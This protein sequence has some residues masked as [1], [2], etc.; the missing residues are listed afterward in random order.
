MAASDDVDGWFNLVKEAIIL[1]ALG[2]C[3]SCRVKS[4]RNDYLGI[5]PPER[6]LAPSGSTASSS[7]KAKARPKL[8]LTSFEQTI[9]QSVVNPDSIVESLDMIGGLDEIKSELWKLVIL[10]MQRPEFFSSLKSKLIS[11]PKGVLLYGAPGTGKTMLAKAIA[12][13]PPLPPPSSLP[14]FFLPFI[15]PSFPLSLLP[16][17]LFTSLT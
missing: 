17:F 10:P 6:D 1:S 12:R 13:C 14:S 8:R 11:S 15:C 9:M 5:A 16:S 7:S 2:L 4:M 3:L